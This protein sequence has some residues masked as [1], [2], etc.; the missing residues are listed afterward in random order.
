MFEDVEQEYLSLSKAEVLEALQYAF[1]KSQP[2]LCTQSRRESASP[3]TLSPGPNETNGPRVHSV[4]ALQYA[5][6]AG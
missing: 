1:G 5:S 2:P 6:G 3:G 4:T